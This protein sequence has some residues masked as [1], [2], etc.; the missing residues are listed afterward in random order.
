MASHD[1][2]IPEEYPCPVCGEMREIGISKKG[3]PYFQCGPCGAQIFIR[4]KLGIRRL[5]A[6]QSNSELKKKLET[7]DVLDSC[8]LLQI[9]NRISFIEEEIAKIEAKGFSFELSKE[10]KAQKAKLAAEKNNLRK[11]YFQI[12][13]ESKG[14]TFLNRAEEV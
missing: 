3:K 7:L 11:E 2:S 1:G 10:Q 5:E 8:K 13:V 9:N 12:L 4:G 14:N 6:I